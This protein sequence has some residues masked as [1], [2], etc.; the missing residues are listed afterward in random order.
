MYP[1]E[2]PPDVMHYPSTRSII[3]AS[4]LKTSRITRDKLPST[5]LKSEIAL[6]DRL[7]ADLATARQHQATLT[8]ILIE[9]TLEAA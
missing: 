5:L 7:N 1:A 3:P 8:K 4:S 6:C 9:T 2:V